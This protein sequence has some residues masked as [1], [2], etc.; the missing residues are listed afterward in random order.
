MSWEATL[1]ADDTKHSKQHTPAIIDIVNA[2]DNPKTRWFSLALICLLTLNAL[3]L[4]NSGLWT[5]PP[6]PH[7]DGPDYE[8]IAYSI[9]N[10][11]GFQFAWSDPQWQAPYRES[12]LANQYTQFER[13]DWPGPTTSRPPLLPI[14]IAT[15][16]QCVP[17][18][19]IAF[20]TL[21]TLSIIAL[22][23]AGALAVIT[24]YSWTTDR[25]HQSNKPLS[26]QLANHLPNL[27]ATITLILAA[28]DRTIRRYNTDFLTEPWA[29]LGVA[30]LMLLLLRSKQPPLPLSWYASLG[31]WLAI[32]VLLRS[33]LI[34]WLPV[35][36]LFALLPV[37]NSLKPKHAPHVKHRSLT[38]IPPAVILAT[39]LLL[40]A[41][42]W[43]RN[44]YV[45]N[46]LMPLGAQGPA[47]L[48]GGYCDEALADSGNWNPTPEQSIQS[49]L[50]T[51]AE[52]KTWSAAQRELALA[53]QATVETVH[54]I[55]QHTND[56]PTLAC[57]RLLTHYGPPRLDHILWK[58]FALLG[59]ILLLKHQPET[60][61]WLLALCLADAFSIALLYETGGRFLIP[62]HP[63]LYALA[64]YGTTQT[65]LA[66]LAIQLSRATRLP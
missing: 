7:G 3:H 66:V 18:G 53:N 14:L 10:G 33:L 50:D 56:L 48:R 11:Q 45:L 2:I 59:L 16:Y 9:A 1:Y 51:L 4:W 24:A 5:A 36:L 30:I 52:S 6:L 13:R 12:Q 47:S 26:P 62:L 25:L 38:W 65:V 35:L 49:H 44:C 8:S 43:I 40:V 34:F 22:S 31:L 15:I 37:A 32:M 28:A 46:S 21:R 27:A 60:A 29:A 17:R 42:W 64:A 41:P 61:K 20:A 57:R 19:P 39:F 23:I 55:Q 63:L 54:W 58:L